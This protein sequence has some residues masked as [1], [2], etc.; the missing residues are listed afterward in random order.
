MPRVIA[1]FHTHSPYS[2]ATSPQITVEALA[3]WGEVK[4]LTLVGTGDFT[5]P[6]WLEKLRGALEEVPGTGLYAPRNRPDPKIWFM[7]TGEISTIFEWEGKTKKIH[8][9]L[10]APSLEDAQLIG[11][12]LSGYGDLEADG[13]PTLNA[14]APEVVEKIFEASPQAVVI[15]AHIWTPWFSL[16]GDRSGFDRLEDCYGDMSTRIFAL[17]TG[18]SSDPLMNW[19]LSALERYALVSNSDCHSFWPWRLGREA[20]IFDLRRV[21]YQEIV[22][23]LR[24]R[25]PRRFRATIEVNPAYG[26]Y[27]WTGHRKC[28]VSMP[29]EDA[30]KRGNLCPK[31]GRRLTKGVDQRVEDLADKPRGY[32]PEGAI[33]YVHLL[34]L[35]EL[36][37]SLLGASSPSV[38]QVW[39]IYNRLIHTF[40]NELRVLLS[41]PYQSLVEEAGKALARAVLD[42][43][44]DRVEVVPGYDGVYGQPIFGDRLLE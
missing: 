19:R 1:D 4:G 20:N 18:L 11:E 44:L 12:A 30:V 34:P 26:K 39:D 33:G 27:H 21:T 9:L 14:P 17:E 41:V 28:G 37:T 8:H 29:P 7:L 31:C 10:L 23:A 36:I 25:D 5:H 40:G 3:K 32:K 42:I 22:E 24:E 38:K 16:F 43:R 35:H 2:R 6:K 15:P 13:R